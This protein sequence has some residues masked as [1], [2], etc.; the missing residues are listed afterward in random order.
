M[1]GA[2]FVA[3]KPYSPPVRPGTHRLFKKNEFLFRVNRRLLVLIVKYKI[4]Y[5]MK[6]NKAKFLSILFVVFAVILSSCQDDADKPS[7]TDPAKEAEVKKVLALREELNFVTRFVDRNVMDMSFAAGRASFAKTTIARM[8]NSAPCAEAIEEELS[9][10]SIKITLD[11]GDGCQADD[12]V[13]VAGKV[14]M[15]FRVNEVTF[16]YALEFID[17]REI[18]GEHQ[19][20]VVNGTV[21]GSFV[22]DLEAEQFLQEMEQALVVTYPNNTEAVY[23]MTQV[24]EMTETGLRVNSLTTSGNFANGGEFSTTVSKALVYDF[25]CEGDLPVQGEELLM[26]QGNTILV[27]Y[28]N[29]TCDD[30]YTIK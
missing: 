10:G 4:N 24:A 14:V 12:G 30:T 25:S 26:F 1:T 17:Y 22:M 27:S 2:W 11:F 7:T 15:I 6:T 8:K 28:G 13:E 29:G 18:S 21:H 19:G 16:E 5:A 3:V 23:N 9:D 20:E